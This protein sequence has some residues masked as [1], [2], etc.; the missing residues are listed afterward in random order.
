MHARR[1]V[2]P[3]QSRRSPVPNRHSSLDRGPLGAHGMLPASHAWA[4][5]LWWCVSHDLV[6]SLRF[7]CSSVQARQDVIV[8]AEP[9]NPFRTG[10]RVVRGVHG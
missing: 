4:R 6:H 8:I 2:P 7:C 5:L 10:Q 9:E 1:M 3:D